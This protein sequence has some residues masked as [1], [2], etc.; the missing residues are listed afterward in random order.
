MWIGEIKKPSVNPKNIF[1]KNTGRSEP[2]CQINAK[3][4]D[5]MFNTV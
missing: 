1:K 5:T 4:S 2:N 3:L